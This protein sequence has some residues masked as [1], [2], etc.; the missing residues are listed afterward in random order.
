[1]VPSDDVYPCLPRSEL[2]LPRSELE[3]RIAEIT[4]LPQFVDAMSPTLSRCPAHHCVHHLFTGRN[5]D[6]RFSARS[7]QRPDQGRMGHGAEITFIAEPC[8]RSLELAQI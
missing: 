1:M 8:H 5:R 7:P 2:G 6:W 4:C 3:R